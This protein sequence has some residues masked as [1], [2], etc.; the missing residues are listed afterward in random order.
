MPPR[1]LL[2]FGI[3]AICIIAFLAYS[4]I[5][6]PTV[7]NSDDSAFDI[8]GD[9]IQFPD[10]TQ[11]PAV[12]YNGSQFEFTVKAKYDINGMLVSKHRYP[13][14]LMRN[15]SPYDYALVWG[16]VPEQLE[17]LKFSQAY[18]Y[19]LF[20]FKGIAPVD[21]QYIQ[22]HMSNNHMIPSTPN[23]RKALKTARKGD[24][25][26]I[27]GYLVNVKATQGNR[28]L[29]RWKTS[30]VRED[31]GDG[32]CEIIYVTRLRIKDKIYE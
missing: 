24:L 14:G 27:E 21:K 28:V 11:L 26:G 10:S 30:T 9:P 19:C 5:T 31:T 15:L 3:A 20:S 32:A 29:S 4:N 18:R 2:I 16:K 22:N 23:L 6:E 17:H 8:S 13:R 25:V 7:V 12:S 1:L